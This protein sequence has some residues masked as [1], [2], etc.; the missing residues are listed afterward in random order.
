[1]FIIVTPLH[2][3]Y[4][5]I[6]VVKLSYHTCDEF[7]F[8]YIWLIMLLPILYMAVFDFLPILCKV[9]LLAFDFPGASKVILENARKIGW[10]PFH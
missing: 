8:F 2:F 3:E 10:D 9:A 1:M 5:H 6:I 7:N 4:L